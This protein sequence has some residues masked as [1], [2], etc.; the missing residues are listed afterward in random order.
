MGQR[1]G[2][3]CFWVVS[4]WQELRIYPRGGASVVILKIIWQIRRWR[5]AGVAFS[6]VGVSGEAFGSWCRAFGIV[7]QRLRYNQKHQG[8]I[9]RNRGK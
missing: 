2:F 6:A 3:C 1:E 8:E 4:G 9:K 5:W 7:S